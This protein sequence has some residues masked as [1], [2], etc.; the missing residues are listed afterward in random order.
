MQTMGDV[1][2]V[3]D[4]EDTD[5]VDGDVLGAA[6]RRRS[7]GMLRLPA[8]PGWRKGSV[9]PGIHA[10]REGLELLTLTPDSN[11]GVFD[12]TNVGAVIRHAAKPQRP[13]RAERLVAFVSRSA[14]APDVVPL[15]F[16]LSNGIFVGT[17]LQQLTLGEFNVEVFGP[18]AFGVR[19]AL[20]PAAPGIDIAVAVRLQP[21]ALV[22][23]QAVNVS[24]QFLGRSLAT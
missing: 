9:A 2:G 18:Q 11:N 14:T 16:V 1:L 17:N 12:S 5:D 3:D 24:L 8:K 23:T 22:G 15:A 10:P 7:A 21:A 19:M 6:I 4:D 13:F 20:T